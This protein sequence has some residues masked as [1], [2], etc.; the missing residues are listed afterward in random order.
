MLHRM[1]AA[2][3]FV[4]HATVNFNIFQKLLHAIVPASVVPNQSK[5]NQLA[6]PSHWSEEPHKNFEIE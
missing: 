3:H 5:D 2:L 4:L 1:C 6:I